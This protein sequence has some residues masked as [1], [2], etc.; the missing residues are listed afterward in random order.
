MLEQATCRAY[1]LVS[2]IGIPQDDWE[3]L[4]QEFVLDCLQRAPGFDPARGDWPAFV[5]GV[6]R[7]RSAIAAHR[8]S[9][10][11]EG[12][13]LSSAWCDLDPDQPG[14]MDS[15]RE[16]REPVSGDPTASLVLS[17]DMQRVIGGLSDNLRNLAIDLTYLS[18]VEA[19]AKSNRSKQRIYQ[20]MGKLRIAFSR[21]GI[22]PER[23]CEEGAR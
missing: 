5:R 10:R 2:R 18:P 4:R 12:E 15:F 11:L 19:A 9:R 1:F 22:L 16:A 13:T 21:A 17:A 20:L 23:F 3:D 14:R 6:I 7:H 8:A